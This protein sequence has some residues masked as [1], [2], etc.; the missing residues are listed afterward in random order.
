MK[1]IWLY[2]LDLK[3]FVHYNTP[4]ILSFSTISYLQASI[5]TFISCIILGY[6]EK[7]TMQNNCW[8]YYL[9]FYILYR[10]GTSCYMN[11]VT[12]DILPF[13]FILLSHMTKL[14]H[15]LH[16][17]E[18]IWIHH[19]DSFFYNLL[20]PAWLTNQLSIPVNF[21]RQHMF[22]WDRTRFSPR[23]MVYLLITLR[24]GISDFFLVLF[25]HA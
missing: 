22:L 8:S 23:R 7:N 25:T 21:V 19:T 14:S 9:R 3:I 24:G 4:V 15:F 13:T 2:C 1:I 12:Q 17:T 6:Q 11:S 18:Y 5:G 16:H 20:T 10:H